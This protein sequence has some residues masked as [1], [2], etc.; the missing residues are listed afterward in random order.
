V[1]CFIGL[2][3]LKRVTP[4]LFVKISIAALLIAGIRLCIDAWLAYR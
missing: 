3:F 2:R 1:G 4:A